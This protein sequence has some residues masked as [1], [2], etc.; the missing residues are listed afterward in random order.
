MKLL[1]LVELHTSLVQLCALLHATALYLR[2]GRGRCCCSINNV[3]DGKDVISPDMAPIDQHLTLQICWLRYSLTCPTFKKWM[4]S[5]RATFSKSA[6]LL[7]RSAISCSSSVTKPSA[8]LSV[9]LCF[10]SMDT[11]SSAWVLWTERTS[12]EKTCTLSSI[13][14]WALAWRHKNM[15]SR[16]CYTSKHR[17][18]LLSEGLTLFCSTECLI[19]STFF[20]L[21]WI[22]CWTSISVFFSCACTTRVHIYRWRCFSGLR[23]NKTKICFCPWSLL[24]ILNAIR[25]SFS[26][27]QMS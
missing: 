12:S 22:I 23:H 20:T 26:Q 4:W 27:W 17:H 25:K 18:S 10:S 19:S 2:T 11:T 21:S 9:C 16:C 3:T 7:F 8:H 15:V 6:F 14:F 13:S 24:I 1:A 5:V